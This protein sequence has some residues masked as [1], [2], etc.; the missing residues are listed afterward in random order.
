M[1][2]PIE[3]KRSITSRAPWI[4]KRFVYQQGLP[5]D[6]LSSLSHRIDICR[7]IAPSM[8]SSLSVN[9]ERTE[10]I[11]RSRFIQRACSNEIDK[12]EYL[13][14]LFS[15]IKSLHKKGVFHGDLCRKNIIFSESSYHLIDFEPFLMSQ[16]KSG[17]R[18]FCTTRP[19]LSQIDLKTATYSETSDLIGFWSFCLYEMGLVPLPQAAAYSL[20][21]LIKNE[22]NCL[23]LV[24]GFENILTSLRFQI[25]GHQKHSVSNPIDGRQSSPANID[26]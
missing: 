25:F 23:D 9:A 8:A 4:E 11:I 14:N 15:V 10:I 26:I 5:K 13:K 6:S 19:Y 3:L 21:R 1:D 2:L 17:R 7:N 16:T 12:H 18:R 24:L 22:P 20:H